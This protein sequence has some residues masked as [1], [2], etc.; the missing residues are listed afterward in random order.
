MIESAG[1]ELDRLVPE[2][3]RIAELRGNPFA[4][5]EWYFATAS[6]VRRIA[7]VRRED[8]TLLGL[9]P[10]VAES[11]RGVRS[12]RFGGH[13]LGD[14]YHPVAELAD[15]TETAASC[16]GALLGVGER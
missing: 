11:W 8:G 10:L 5:P 14:R 3:R 4:T 2:W 13:L 9:L 16:V 15:E 7:A 6:E 12:L 1:P